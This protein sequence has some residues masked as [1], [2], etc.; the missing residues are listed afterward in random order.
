MLNEP[1]WIL[2]GIVM[3]LLF[4]SGWCLLYLIWASSR[5]VL[6]TV[7]LFPAAFSM[8][9]LVACAALYLAGIDVRPILPLIFRLGAPIA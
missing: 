8:L 3:F 5:S 6:K 2:I 1:Q 4:A 9:S 7:L